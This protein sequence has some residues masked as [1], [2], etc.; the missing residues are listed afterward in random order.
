MARRKKEVIRTP[1]YCVE[2]LRK[3][4]VAPED[5]G[6]TYAECHAWGLTSLSGIEK[7]LRVNWP[8]LHKSGVTQRSKK[9]WD[10]LYYIAC[11]RN[12][13]RVNSIWRVTFYN[14]NM[15]LEG[16][17]APP[18]PRHWSSWTRPLDNLHTIGYVT[19]ETSRRRGRSPR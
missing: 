15:R 6:I 7:F 18:R 14:S 5:L 8:D 2:E 3:P 1:Q 19:A 4:R 9:V 10:K 12:T 11:P 13:D 16:T 17:T